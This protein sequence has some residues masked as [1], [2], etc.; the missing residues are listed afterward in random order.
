MTVPLC[1]WERGPDPAGPESLHR[2]E[3]SSPATCSGAAGSAGKF[4]LG[5]RR[6]PRDPEEAAPAPQT[7]SLLAARV[8]TAR[9]KGARS[10]SWESGAAGGTRGRCGRPKPSGAAPTDTPAGARPRPPERAPL[11]SGSAPFLEGSASGSPARGAVS[12]FSLPRAAGRQE[13][14]REA[15][16]PSRPR[17]PR[18]NAD[19]SGRERAV[20]PTPQRASAL[21]GSPTCLTLTQAAP[22]ALRT[23]SQTHA[24]ARGS[25]GRTPGAAWA[26][27]L[28][29]S[30]SPAFY[31]A[32]AGRGHGQ[33][34]TAR[35]RL[36]P[37]Q[38]AVTASLRAQTDRRRRRGPVLAAPA[39]AAPSPRGLEP[40]LGRA[41]LP[42]AA[43]HPAPHPARPPRTSPAPAPHPARRSPRSPRSRRSRSGGTGGREPGPGGGS[44]R[45]WPP[46]HRPRR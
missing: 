33:L 22:P 1:T 7:P 12:V 8:F 34:P 13:E 21:P 45:C 31:G 40:R 28:L 32:G 11:R 20:G 44:G 16:A 19:A 5:G 6:R 46:P 3:P 23:A 15:F 29:F 37:Q 43:P 41:P 25:R 14:E 9:T 42:M 26:P 36:L 30:L 18:P 27:G 24:L 38:V 4:W 2:Q 35:K 17:P 39:A 10:T